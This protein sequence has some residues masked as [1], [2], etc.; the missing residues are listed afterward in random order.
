[1][2]N[3][4]H[5]AL[6]QSSMDMTEDMFRGIDP[7]APPYQEDRPDVRTTER[8]EVSRLMSDDQLR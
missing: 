7:S 6:S 2:P 3:D 1:M 8:S 4:Y 5:R